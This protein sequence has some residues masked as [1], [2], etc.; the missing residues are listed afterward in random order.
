MDVRLLVLVDWSVLILL[1]GSQYTPGSKVDEIDSRRYP[2][3]WHP[4]GKT[5]SARWRSQHYALR[6]HQGRS[7]LQETALVEQWQWKSLSGNSR[8]VRPKTGWLVAELTTRLKAFLKET[9]DGRLHV[10]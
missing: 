2:G 5:G 7:P 4:L 10:L 3:P 6:S 1:E 8:I 9:V